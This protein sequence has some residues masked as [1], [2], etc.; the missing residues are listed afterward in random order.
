MEVKCMKRSY[1]ITLVVLI[2]C[3]L[4]SISLYLFGYRTD[5]SVIVD[6]IVGGRTDIVPTCVYEAPLEDHYSLKI[7]HIEDH[8]YLPVIYKNSYFLWKNEATNVPIVSQLASRRVNTNNIYDFQSIKESKMNYIAFM[9]DKTYY[10]VV[11]DSDVDSVMLHFNDDRSGISFEQV[12]PGIFL[13][14]TTKIPDLVSGKSKDSNIVKS[15]YPKNNKSYYINSYVD[16]D[17]HTEKTFSKPVS[18]KSVF[19]YQ[20]SKDYEVID[21]MNQNLLKQPFLTIVTNRK[22][23]IYQNTTFGHVIEIDGTTTLTYYRNNEDII[24]QEYRHYNNN[25]RYYTMSSKIFEPT[26]KAL[27]NFE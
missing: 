6:E 24:L 27:L 18:L 9:I 19:D 15:A 26:Y 16:Y 12:A 13:A 17:T 20:D 11:I 22:E 4:F 25:Y 2:I 10:Y 8:E 7:F 23:P 21:F 3:S 5:E 1:H 14:Q